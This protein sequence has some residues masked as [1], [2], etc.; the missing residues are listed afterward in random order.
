NGGWGTNYP[1]FAQRVAAA[2]GLYD[3]CGEPIV[4]VV[5]DD[6]FGKNPNPPGNLVPAINGNLFLKDRFI[7]WA[8]PFTPFENPS[9]TPLA[10][11]N[12][13]A[14][15]FEKPGHPDEY[16]LVYSNSSTL[17]NQVFFATYDASTNSVSQVSDPTLGLEAFGSAAPQVRFAVSQILDNNGRN[18]YVV[19]QE[20]EVRS[21]PI[22]SIGDIF[23]PVLLEARGPLV[24]LLSAELELS[25]DG[26]TLAWATNSLS[27]ETA[28]IHFFDLPTNTHTTF[29]LAPGAFRK[30]TGLEFLA[31]G[32]LAISATWN[33]GYDVF[34]G[35]TI[36]NTSLTGLNHISGSEDY[37][38]SMLELGVDGRYLL[39]ANK[40]DHILCVHTFFHAISTAYSIDLMTTPSS[41]LFSGLNSAAAVSGALPDQIDGEFYVYPLECPSDG[42]P[43]P[44]RLPEE[45]PEV[46]LPPD[47]TFEPLIRPYSP[48]R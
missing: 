24:D 33:G 11:E 7:K 16:F 20:N 5:N 21:I 6:V 43:S 27:P 10:T 8:K 36:F 26:R 3:E 13:E 30:I 2:N 18:V 19:T 47:V 1:D 4:Y 22:S 48:L 23:A 34:N 17:G 12:F 41:G 28:L 14:P 38:N 9:P 32:R 35:V 45:V 37:A 46:P 42:G 15:L 31:D 29:E 40:G 25:H 44:F 39:Y